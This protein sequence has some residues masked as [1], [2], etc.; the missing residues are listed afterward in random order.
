M[1]PDVYTLDAA[2]A[3]TPLRVDRINGGIG[4][5][6]KLNSLGIHSGDTVRVVRSGF[7][8]GPILISIHSMEVAL[9]RGMARSISVRAL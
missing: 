9:G 5:R 4:I 2:P 8:G 7:M 6:R 1:T 3:N